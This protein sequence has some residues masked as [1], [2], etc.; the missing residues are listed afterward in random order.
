MPAAVA[1]AARLAAAPTRPISWCT[2]A[3]SSTRIPTTPPTGPSP[4]DLLDGVPAPLAVIP[5]NHDIGFYGEDAERSRRLATFRDTWGGDRFR[6]DLA[7]WRL[8]GADAYL[9]GSAEHDEWLARCRGDHERPVLVFVHQPLDDPERDGWE[10]PAAA[11]V[12]FESAVAGADVRV[13]ASG[14]RHRS[15]SLGRAVWAPSLTLT[16]DG[17]ARRRP[18]TRR[19]RARDRRRRHARPPR[20]APVGRGQ[21]SSTVSTMTI[22]TPLKMAWAR[23][24]GPMRRNR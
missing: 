18:A 6:L 15:R 2:P 10:M 14:H 17:D 13:V 20:R 21:L 12:A 19:R 7:G 3:T 4:D 22:T 23:I 5:G 1:A 16:G 11:T 8:V 24:V 9:L